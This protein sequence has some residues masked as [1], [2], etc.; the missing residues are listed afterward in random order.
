MFTWKHS[1]TVEVQADASQI[2]AMWSA[3]ETWPAW[4]VELEW[5]TLSG[6]FVEGAKGEMKPKKGPRISFEL[7]QVRPHESFMDRAR[8]PLT[9]LDFGHFYT[10][11]RG[12]A[13]SARI[14]HTVEFHGLLAPVFGFLIG[15]NIKQH[16]RPA[17]MELAAR[18]R[19]V[20]RTKDPAA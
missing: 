12:P 11:A 4:D 16:L 13:D 17:M 10:P 19:A 18:A 3:P 20:D 15:R 14:T 5:V 6:G 8:L 1:E 9:T 2:W 7:I